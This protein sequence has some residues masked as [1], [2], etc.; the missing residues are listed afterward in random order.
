MTSPNHLQGLRTV[1]VYFTAPYTQAKAVQQA[2]SL[3]LAEMAAEHSLSGH[4][5]V[6]QELLEINALQTWMEIYEAVPRSFDLGHFKVA[7]TAL[8][9]LIQG[10]RQVE[11]FVEVL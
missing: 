4:L 10:E 2:A 11:V 3:H 8:A 9:R 7:S 6:R 1:Y 5:Q